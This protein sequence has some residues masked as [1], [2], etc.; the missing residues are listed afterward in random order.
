MNERQSMIAE[1]D[2]YE[3]RDFVTLVI[4]DDEIRRP[5]L[6]RYRPVAVLEE[7]KHTMRR[8][9]RRAL[10]WPSL[11]RRD[12]SEPA[13]RPGHIRDTFLG[14]TVVDFVERAASVHCCPAV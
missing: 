10:A 7:P 8:E 11:L 12:T 3:V 4:A 9:A 5:E 2:Y 1:V 13:I 6:C 14:I